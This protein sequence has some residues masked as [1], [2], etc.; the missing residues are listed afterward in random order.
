[1]ARTTHHIAGKVIAI[2]GAG[3]GI[4]K[5]TARAL[6]Q[7]GAKV[8]IGDI[9]L[10]TA[11]ATA[12]ELG[13]SA[14]AVRL[15]VT[16]RAS[17]D[18]FLDQVEATLGPIDVLINNAGIMPTV[19]FLDEDEASIDRQFAINVRGVMH[20]M[21]AVI[22]RMLNRGGGHVINVASTAGKFGVPGVATYCAT[23]HAVVGLSNSVRAELRDTPVDLSVVMPVIVRTELTDG[24][25]DTR[26]VKTLQ[27]QDVA[28]SIVEAIQTRRY[29]V[30]CPRS[31]HAIYRATT[32]LPLRA[33]DLFAQVTK[34][35][36]AMLVAIDSP[37]RQAYLTRINEPAQL[38]ASTAGSDS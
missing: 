11:Q 14:P 4:G 35:E 38:P 3:R 17:V 26:G 20:G 22:P 6:T 28:A 34:A 2:T 1:M 15:D 25:P 12:Q 13:L 5:A 24:V 27:P 37:A 23:K 19:R 36:D 29:E 9:D 31:V 16:D 10:D 33:N 8:A 21:R 32:L 30:W 18:A 7:Q